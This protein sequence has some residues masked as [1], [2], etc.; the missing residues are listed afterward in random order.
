MTLFSNKLY[1]LF[2]FAEGELSLRQFIETGTGANSVNIY[3]DN[4]ASD[5]D[6]APD[7]LSLF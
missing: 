4:S 3:H 2:T 1:N 5:A 7:K 6:F